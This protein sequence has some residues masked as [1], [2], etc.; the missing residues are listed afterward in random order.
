MKKRFLVIAIAIASLSIFNACEKEQFSNNVDS[1]PISQ[2]MFTVQENMLAFGSGQEVQALI[3]TLLEEKDEAG[4]LKEE[5][6]STFYESLFKEPTNLKSGEIDVYN[7]QGYDTLVPNPEFARLLNIDGEIMVDN[8]VYKISPYGTYYFP[9]EKKSRFYEI[10]NNES[11]NLKS[12]QIQEELLGQPID[13]HTYLIEDDIFRYDTYAQASNVE[14]LQVPDEEDG[15]YGGGSGG[16]SS[17][18]SSSSSSEPNYDSF[19]TFLYGAQT[20]F[21]KAFEGLFGRNKGESVEVSSSR[22]I[23]VNFYNYDY[24]FYEE[25]GATATFQK[26]N[27]I[28]WSG[29][30]ADELRVG[31]YGVKFVVTPPQSVISLYPPNQSKM[32]GGVRTDYVP[33]NTKLW[34]MVELWEWDVTDEFNDATKG[35]LDLLESLSKQLN[36]PVNVVKNYKAGKI[37]YYFVNEELRAYNAEKI[38][39]VFTSKVSASISFSPSNP[40]NSLS[41]WAQNMAT[42]QIQN[43]DS[44][45]INLASGNVY[46]CAK[47][48]G[49]WKGVR[50]IKK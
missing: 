4:A 37:E 14:Y 35:I 33:G 19:R 23:K 20:W 27:W 28:G 12:A 5:L 15:E 41:G 6:E 10:F 1:P 34:N 48:A 2:T 11:D 29:T 49:V 31:W 24:V 46:G 21:G 22:R 45:D 42:T 47:H 44:F 36:K 8:I 9:K 43:F 18:G 13:E 16:S 50:V 25:C 32:Q 30:S 17:G 39:Q 3:T 38:N 7:I 26:K 40:P